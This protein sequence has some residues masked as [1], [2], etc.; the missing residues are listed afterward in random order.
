MPVVYAQQEEVVRV[1]K[2]VEG[3]L[4]WCLEGMTTWKEKSEE[5]KTADMVACLTVWAKRKGMKDEV[6]G[7]TDT[8]IPL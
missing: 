6:K 7:G 2:R 5:E 8:I 4:E 3:A 1:K